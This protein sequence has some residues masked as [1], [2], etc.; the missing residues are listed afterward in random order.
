MKMSNISSQD[1]PTIPA[2]WALE[3]CV[4][5][6]SRPAVGGGNQFDG[7]IAS[8]QADKNHFFGLQLARATPVPPRSTYVVGLT[9]NLRKMRNVDSC[10]LIVREFGPGG[11]LHFQ[12]Q[13]RITN[14]SF[15]TYLTVRDGDR[16]VQPVLLFA[17]A[18]SGTAE[19]EMTIATLD[20]RVD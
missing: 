10:H 15:Q 6:N 16:V 1:A 8:P 20:A 12:V 2:G 13:K 5:V 4:I 17:T 19:V 18:A 3:K 9:L 11:V 14:G 7:A